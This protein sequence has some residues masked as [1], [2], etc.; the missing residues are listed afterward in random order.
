MRLV[1][2]GVV[3]NTRQIAGDLQLICSTASTAADNRI[4][5]SGVSVSSRLAGPVQAQALRLPRVARVAFAVAEALRCLR[6][7]QKTSTAADVRQLESLLLY[8]LALSPA[9]T[10]RGAHSQDHDFHDQQ[11]QTQGFLMA[12]AARACRWPHNA[13]EPEIEQ[14]LDLCHASCS[15]AG[16]RERGD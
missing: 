7:A 13:E 10:V 4:T 2:S 16:L 9:A 12:G 1:R 6:N 5:V 3:I 11:P 8:M 15:N 14:Q